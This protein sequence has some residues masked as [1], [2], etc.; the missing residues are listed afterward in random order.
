LNY[1]VPGRANLTI[2]T[3]E[4]RKVEKIREKFINRN[5]KYFT[6]KEL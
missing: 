5:Y 1:S 6:T 3:S 4:N 2:T